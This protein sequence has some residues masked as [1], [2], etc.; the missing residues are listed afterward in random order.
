MPGPDWTIYYFNLRTQM[1]TTFSSE[2]GRP[3]DA[4]SR[5]VITINQKVDNDTDTMRVDG[6]DNYLWMPDMKMWKRS[7]DRG[8]DFLDEDGIPYDARLY[9]LDIPDPYYHQVL[10]MAASDSN[11]PNAIDRN[12]LDRERQLRF[13]IMVANAVEPTRAERRVD[14]HMGGEN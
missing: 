14:P 11:Y 2:D 8:V 4:P 6:T 3:A 1:L 13:D 9:G 7:D 10:R 5:Y 12:S